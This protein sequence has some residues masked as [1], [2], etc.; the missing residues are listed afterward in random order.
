MSIQV[1]HKVTP[2]A[3]PTLVLTCHV[4]L[5]LSWMCV[6]RGCWGKEEVQGAE[7]AAC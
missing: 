6:C 1:M 3:N 4:V 2:Y 5:T 7:E